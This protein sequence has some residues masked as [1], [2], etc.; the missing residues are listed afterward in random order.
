MSRR[1]T[2]APLV[3]G[4]VRVVG[5]EQATYRLVF[6]P[7]PHVARVQAGGRGEL[8]GRREWVLCEHSVEPEAI[9]QV[10]RYEIHGADGVRG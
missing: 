7:L 5:F 2:V 6:E 4:R 3:I 9:A 10:H 1:E 8:V